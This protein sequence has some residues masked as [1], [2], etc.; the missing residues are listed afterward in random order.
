MVLLGSFDP[1]ESCIE[2][3]TVPWRI[4][5]LGII[6]LGLNRV[7]LPVYARVLEHLERRVFRLQ[8]I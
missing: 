4:L 3:R 1:L 6:L 7:E 8:F 2:L 5:F